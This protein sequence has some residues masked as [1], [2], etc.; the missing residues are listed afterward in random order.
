MLSKTEFVPTPEPTSHLCTVLTKPLPR[1][2]TVI[3][4]GSQHLADVC[5]FDNRN[6][7]PVLGKQSAV[8]GWDRDRPPASPLR[9]TKTF[10]CR[11]QGGRGGV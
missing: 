3:I 8:R 7:L 6:G 4:T 11:T 9:F 5:H 2:D 10:Q 1:R